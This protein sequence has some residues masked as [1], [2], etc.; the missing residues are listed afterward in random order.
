M[1]KPWYKRKL[2][3]ITASI[4]FVL[5]VGGFILYSNVN[6]MLSDALMK[7][8]DSGAISDVYELKFENLRV[9]IFQG[10][11]KVFNLEMKPREKPLQNY[12][13]INSSFKL[14]TH[15]ILLKNVQ[16]MELLQNQVLKL[17]KIV[18]EKPDITL[19][20]SGKVPVLFPFKDSTDVKKPGDKNVKKFLDSFS[21]QK[22]ELID[23]N[24]N[25]TN[26]Y[27]Q[28]EF[29]V[30]NLNF[31]FNELHIS[32]GF[33][34]DTVECKSIDFSIES[35]SGILLKSPIRQFSFENFQ[36]RIEELS[37]QKSIDTLI[38]KIDD[39]STG[40]SALNI[41]TADS[42]FEIGV[43]T[44]VL[45]YKEKSI[46]LEGVSFAPNLSEPDMQKRFQYQNTQ[47]SAR[48]SSLQIKNINFD[49]LFY[50]KKL[51]I[52]ELII[53]SAAIAIFKDKTKPMDP[54]RFPEY[55]GQQIGG[56]KMPLLIKKVTAKNS[57][58]V[59]RERKPDGNYAKVTVS[60]LNASV[61]NVTTIS[62]DQPLVLSGGALLENTAK[63]NL[64]LKFDYLNPQFS[65]DAS[66][67][68][69]NLTGLNNLLH[70]YTPARVDAGIVDGI[71]LSGTAFKTKGVGTLKFLYHDLK[72][73]LQ[74]KEKAQWKSD[75]GA[76][77]ANTVLNSSNPVDSGAPPRVVKYEVMRDQQKGFINIVLKSLLTGLK[78]T[79][80]PSKENRKEDQEKKK[81]WRL[82]KKEEKE[83]KK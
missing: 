83:D 71:T 52:D 77:A 41:H 28:R 58:I 15:K 23:A 19:S 60:N 63:F 29:K 2:F 48:V 73:D 70:A 40:I 37:I 56:I 64:T 1:K 26:D 49:S 17:E 59:N 35:A 51:F 65:I 79:M 8:F 39:F 76:F 18:I 21:L 54:N 14:T 78:E 22:F 6:R 31:A 33:G 46:N 55:L 43:K 45:S 3:V 11:I 42:I 61:E 9:D 5:L 44:F 16:I 30:K 34:K 38:Y 7:T 32:Q 80:I 75:L 81:K 74:L 53:D 82:K 4:L 68:T 12:P 25:T 57:T 24:F 66:I 27:A 10:N 20:L 47:F 72:I 50:N 62:T 69:F 13:Y 67:S 36:I